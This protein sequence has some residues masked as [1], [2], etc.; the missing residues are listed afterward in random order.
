[1][2][3]SENGLR[4]MGQPM[5]CAYAPMEASHSMMPHR[6]LSI[7]LVLNM[8]SILKSHVTCFLAANLAASRGKGKQPDFFYL[9]SHFLVVK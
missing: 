3:S 4:L 9:C 8:G 5:N 6:V 7:S 1:M 2:T